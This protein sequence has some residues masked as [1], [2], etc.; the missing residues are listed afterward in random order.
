MNG[1]VIEHYAAT[2]AVGLNEDEFGQWFMELWGHEIE[3]EAEQDG[4][5]TDKDII[6]TCEEWELKPP[7][8]V[9]VSVYDG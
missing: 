9:Y 8:V 5:P 7:R 3:V 4:T 1:I 6:R 2:G